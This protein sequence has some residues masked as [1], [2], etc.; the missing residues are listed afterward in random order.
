M[1]LFQLRKHIIKPILALA[2][3]GSLLCHSGEAMAQDPQFSQFYANPLYL[4]PAFAGAA[5]CPRMNLITRTQWGGIS[6]FV[7]HSVSY[8]QHVDALNGGIGM[9]VLNDRAGANIL[10]TTTASAMYSYLM[11]VT[12]TFTIKAGA[13]ATFIQKRVDWSKLTFGDQIDPRRGFVY[14]TGE[15]PYTEAI[16]VPD[17]SVGVIGF[18]KTYFVGFAV[19]HLTEP[20]ESVTSRQ[21]PLPRKYTLHGGVNI[22]LDDRSDDVSISPNLIFMQQGGA[23]QTMFGFYANKGPLVGGLWY[24]HTSLTDQFKNSDALSI[25]LGVQLDMM[26]FGYSYDLT[27]SN[28]NVSRTYGSH[29]FSLG[30]QFPCMPKRKKI[31]VMRCPSF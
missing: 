16:N 10:N 25:L 30:L 13:Q 8:D 4:N 3:T 27:V 15:V 24:R 26:K 17:F 23:Q 14:Q 5:R 7:T 29:E 20:N 18:T 11:P 1:L 19:H 22:P 12:H 28:L 6:P 9:V 21:S 31:R 2:V